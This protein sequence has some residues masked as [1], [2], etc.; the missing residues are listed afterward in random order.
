[1]INDLFLG[2]IGLAT[3]VALQ[4]PRLGFHLIVLIACLQDP[5][6][7]LAVGTPALMAISGLPVWLSTCVGTLRADPQ[8]WPRFERA[9]SRLARLSRWFVV[10]LIPPALIVFSY[11][12]GAWQVALLGAFAYLAPLVTMV[13]G[14]SYLDQ[15]DRLS[16]F[17]RFY[18]L[19]VATALVGTGLEYTGLETPLV[20]TSAMGVTWLRFTG[21]G[22]APIRLMSGFF[23]SPDIM[24]WHAA[25]LIMAALTLAL[26]PGRR[27]AKL[28][29]LALAGW[30]FFCVIV[31]GRRKMLLMPIVWTIF[32]LATYA[33]A[34]RARAVIGLLS[35]I[36][37]VAAGFWLVTNEGVISGDYYSYAARSIED[38]PER[39]AHGT[40]GAL[41]YTLLQ[42]GVLGR[43]IGTATQG[44][45]H[46]EGGPAQGWQES[47]ASKLLVELG[48]PGF[49]CAMLVL[50]ALVRGARG[51]LSRVRIGTPAGVRLASLFGM[52]VANAVSF[53]VSHQVYG[54]LTTVTLSAFLLGIA[55][56]GPR[57]AQSPPPRPPA[58]LRRPTGLAS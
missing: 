55:L 29:W 16:S 10:C 19:V 38:A 15:A 43:G 49:L 9:Y 57:W 1:M 7:K 47:G 31:G 2:F 22:G 39:F 6:R 4:Q 41:Y 34:G 8:L 5:I 36:G 12:L 17:L 21:D 48:A 35:A 58:A 37:F 44:A 26:A 20:G 53:A 42:S 32:M 25:T 51:S 18:V 3:L 28:V 14:F 13:I 33:R 52:L 54:D 40:L 23:R 27:L 30:G 50:A 45:Q 56:S 46:I 11:G 24:G